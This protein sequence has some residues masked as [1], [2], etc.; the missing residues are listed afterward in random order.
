[1]LFVADCPIQYGL[2]AVA[3]PNLSWFVLILIS[4]LVAAGLGV[5]VEVA[6]FAMFFDEDRPRRT[7]RLCLTSAGVAGC[8]SAVAG[9]LLLFSRTASGRAV[10]F[11]AEAVP[12]SMWV[13]GESLPVCAGF[14][15]AAAWTLGYPKRRDNQIERL[16]G[17][18]SELGRFIDWLDRDQQKQVGRTVPML[19][20]GLL[21]TAPAFSQGAIAPPSGAAASAARSAA[22]ASSM[23]VSRHHSSSTG[24]AAPAEATYNRCLIY[25]DMTQ[26]V[27][28]EF[29]RQT[30]SR[31]RDTLPNFVEA[32]HCTNLGMGTFADEGPFSPMTEVEI[33]QRPQTEDCAKATPKV[34]GL[35]KITQNA[36]GFQEYYRKRAETECRGR[37]EI[38]LS[39]FRQR[40]QESVKRMDVAL[41]PDLPPR[42]QCTAINSLLSAAVERG[43]TLVVLT[44][45]S[46]T[47]ERG[48]RAFQLPDHKQLIFILLPSR[49]SVPDRGRAALRIA[50]QWKEHVPGM[51]VVLPS[52]VTPQFWSALAVHS[53]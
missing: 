51:W 41:N 35:E 21:L 42:G 33:V 24:N 53:R 22:T 25:V 18:L 28:P 13:L 39:A 9:T 11:L 38:Q 10:D 31:I 30:V 15:S 32:F 43:R 17:R 34:E 47:C 8:L 27:E 4:M 3:F 14:L 52:D 46:E 50:K 37:M 48:P 44:D 16:K 40:S 19:L 6:A 12:I 26:S 36:S 29:R 2:N 45:G 23:D 7:V 1:V 20:V 5:V 49:G